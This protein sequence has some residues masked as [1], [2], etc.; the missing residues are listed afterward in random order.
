MGTL[1]WVFVTSS[2]GL[3]GCTSPMQASPTPTPWPTP[4]VFEK[5]T[6][7][8]QRGTIADLFKLTGEVVPVIWEPIYFRVGGKLASLSVIEGDAV[9]PGDVLAELE[10]PALLEELNQAQLTLEQAQDRLLQHE[11]SRNYALERARLELRRAEILL[12]RAGQTGDETEIALQEIEV[13][14]AELELQKV[15]ADVDPTLARDVIKASLAVEAL[16]RQIEERRLRAPIA[17]QVVAIGIGLEGTRRSLERPQAGD[18][19]PALDPVVVVAK[20]EPLEISVP[21]KDGTRVF[22]LS[23]GQVIT[24]THPWARQAPFIAQVAVTPGPISAKDR[25]G[26]PPDAVYIALPE[27]HPE[28]S[29]GDFV[30]IDVLAD[31][32]S[33]TLVLPVPAV[34]RFAGRTFVVVRE[35]DRQRRVDIS[36]GLETSTEVEVLSGLSEGDVVVGP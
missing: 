9:Q 33:D 8:V 36:I 13:Q 12:Q 3:S 17:G 11:N 25:R 22:E 5:T 2:A 15:E 34:R 21:V 19:V 27:D 1:A 4:A 24:V 32:H 18:A 14:L 16:E 20:S 10:M 31:V 26:N 7:T 35:G 6:Y 23:V 30:D 29:I 28:M